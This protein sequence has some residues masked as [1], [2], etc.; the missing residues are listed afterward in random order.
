M[1]FIIRWNIS[2]NLR[3]CTFSFAGLSTCCGKALFVPAGVNGYLNSKR[4][5]KPVMVKTLRRE[6]FMPVI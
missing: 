6:S 3:P 5:M 4:L 1:K 2:A